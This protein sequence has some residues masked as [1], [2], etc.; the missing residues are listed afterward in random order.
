LPV[1]SDEKG[2]IAKSFD[3]KI[4]DTYKGQDVAKMKDSRGSEI[5]HSTAERTTFVVATDGKIIA[6]IGGVAGDANAEQALAV[7]Q[8]M[9]A[10]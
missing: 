2:E 1:A 10:R 3:I 6:T 5:G 9:A 7:V 8:R 4:T